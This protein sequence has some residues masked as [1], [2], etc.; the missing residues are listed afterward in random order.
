MKLLLY[1]SVAATLI[2]SSCGK[3]FLEVD[4]IG[5]LGKEQVFRDIVGLKNALDGSYN[6]MAR[7]HMNEY[8]V[9]GDLRGDD[10]AFR[11]GISS[12]VMQT[13]FNYVANDQDEAGATRLMWGNGYAALNNIN[14]IINGA[15]PFLESS[16]DKAQATSIL[17]QALLLRALCNFDMTNIYAQQYNYSPDASHLGI[18]I[19]LKT[20]PAGTH[21]A[22]ES[23]SAVYAQILA[24]IEQC[25]QLLSQ[26]PN[27]PTKIYA[28]VDAAKAL[29]ARI[30]LYMGQYQNVVNQT[31]E[32]IVPNKYPLVS[33]A[34]YKKMF[35]ASAQRTDYTSIA[36]EVIWQFNLEKYAKGTVQHLFSEPV[37]YQYYAAPGYVS[38]FS[39][40]D[41]RKTMLQIDPATNYYRSIKYGKEDGVINDNWPLNVKVVRSAE[42]YLNRAEAN[43]RLGNYAEAVSDIKLLQAR[44]RNVSTDLI[45]IAYTTP[46]ELFAIIKLERRKEL[47]FENQRIYDI[48]RYKESL[49]RGTGCTSNLCQLTYPNDRFIMPIP[50]SE[51]DI[52]PLMQPNPTVNQ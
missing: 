51:L 45:T 41:I 32:L 35:T 2:L 3:S 48:M 8:G 29:R 33:S 7:Y 4:P 26:N 5:K 13:E 22:R 34:D 46:E 17:G 27:V 30:Y 42:L 10:V 31:S 25:I 50:R 39:D 16:I 1:S 9:Y 20:P 11:T 24:D 38:L 37:E 43:F 28:S 14:N 49:N 52:N 44:A 47:G 40:Q 18:P 36:S 12:P 15:E 21:V 6:L 23:V 19:L